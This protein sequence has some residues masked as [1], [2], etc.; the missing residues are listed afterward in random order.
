MKKEI[1]EA[2]KEQSNALAELI[3]ID[4]DEEKLEKIKE[5]WSFLSMFL[6]GSYSNLW[7]LTVMLCILNSTTCISIMIPYVSETYKE[8][9]L[10]SNCDPF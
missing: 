6:K 2:I 1:N 5:Y 8:V 7:F 10:N 3:D 4:F 9:I